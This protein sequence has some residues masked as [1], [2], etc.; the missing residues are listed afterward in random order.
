[1]KK[2]LTTLALFAI[3]VSL[4]A[5][6]QNANWCFPYTAKV[7]FNG[8]S[9]S[10]GQCN[11]T[12]NISDPYG[13]TCASVSN[14]NGELLFYSD[15]VKVWDKTGAIMPGGQ[16]I[17]GGISAG[18]WTEQG[19]VI[20][21]KPGSET[22]Y[23]IFTACKI[24]DVPHLQNHAGFHY[25]VVD[26]TLNGGNGAVILNKVPLKDE[27]GTDID[28]DVT[29]GT[30][31]RIYESSITTALNK[32]G[33]AIWVTLFTRFHTNNVV[34]RI[35]YSYLLGSGTFN[36]IPF[37][38]SPLPNNCPFASPTCLDIGGSIK[39]SPDGKYLLNEARDLVDLYLFDNDNAN[40][41]T[42]GSVTYQRR[43][44]TGVPVASMPGYGIEFSPGSNRIYFSTF[45]CGLCQE[46][47]L[48][49]YESSGNDG[50]R[51][52]YIRIRQANVISQKGDTANAN[53]IIGEFEVP[54]PNQDHDL[55]IIPATTYGDL[56]LAPNGKIYACALEA[57][58]SPSNANLGVINQPDQLGINCQYIN[59]GVTLSPGT[60]QTG[61]LPQWVHKITPVVWPKVYFAK[62]PEYFRRD[63]NG[64]L[65]LFLHAADVTLPNLNHI[66]VLPIAPYTGEYT[67][68]YTP[69]GITNYTKTHQGHRRSFPLHSGDVEI[70]ELLP[71]NSNSIY[72]N[73]TTG[74]PSSNPT[75]VP[76][77]ENIIAESNTGTFITRTHNYTALYV[78]TSTYTSPPYFTT[79][80]DGRY[81]FNPATNNLFFLPNSIYHPFVVHHLDPITNLLTQSYSITFT[82]AFRFLHVDNQDNVFVLENSVLKQ[83]NYTS[84]TP[85]TSLVSIAG[86][87]NT[88]CRQ[89]T[90]N[91][92]YTRN[93]CLVMHNADNKIYAIDFSS[94]TL[95]SK[96]IDVS[97][98]NDFYYEYYLIDGDKVYLTGCTNTPLASIGNQAIPELHHLMNSF[99]TKLSLQGDFS[100]MAAGISN[101]PLVEKK[102]S[103]DVTL[104]PNPSNNSIQ[105]LI[106]ENGKQ[107]TSAY[108]L[109]IISQEGYLLLRKEKYASGNKLNISSLKAG[110][111][112]VE[113][114]NARGEKVSRE[115]MKL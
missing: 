101:E 13:Y 106:S 46:N 2:V 23:Y 103:L 18:K 27:G 50:S 34:K 31:L 71:P 87:S 39:I 40:P 77:N 42:G 90:C 38:S 56:Q 95:T 30:G 35:A 83:Y 70:G 111:Y 72:F 88:D 8:T 114:L 64:N 104:S 29:A 26:I 11:N 1:M 96:K 17:G 59:N 25:S 49:S 19:I 9:V 86:F 68:Q 108:T 69:A 81:V 100:R 47:P 20:V 6:L 43:V 80:F 98:A 22:I 33:N 76:L 28:Y 92:Q 93:M 112:H 3:T 85:N 36:P 67:F 16:N 61:S 105:A 94:G 53:I 44:Y 113:I 84:I 60:W 58:I 62:H 79:D 99:I 89:L 32:A 78:H 91:D 75:N 54:P 51:K 55:I 5:Q 97:N 24:E 73:G 48:Q 12:N 65:L 4:F 15:G 66:G 57:V 115:F 109:S 52:N 21:P 41:A 7:T 74:L 63:E 37:Y 45:D 14:S 102:S 82:G 10:T 110:A 107:S